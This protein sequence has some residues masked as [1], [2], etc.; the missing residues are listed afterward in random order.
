M[1]AVEF[2]AQLNSDQTL[3]VPASV[4]GTIPMG[5]T[6]RVREPAEPVAAN[7]L[8]PQYLVMARLEIEQILPRAKGD[9]RG[10]QPLVD[11]ARCA[12]DTG[13]LDVAPGIRRPAGYPLV[14][15]STSTLVRAFPLVRRWT[16]DHR[17]DAFGRAT[18][19][20][21]HLA[22]DP[23]ALLVRPSGFSRVG[24]HR[25]IET[26]GKPENRLGYSGLKRR[27]VWR[28]VFGPPARPGHELL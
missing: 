12:F 10:I 7:C 17:P 11:L 9:D 8:S 15:S 4:I 19:A 16:K 20:A 18:V 14:Q 24:T 23:D 5:Q 6:V 27:I 1:K 26:R 13:R 25:E 2:Q 21:L 28:A 22:D 3:T